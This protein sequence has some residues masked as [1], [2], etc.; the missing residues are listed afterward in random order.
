MKGQLAYRCE[1]GFSKWRCMVYAGVQP[2]RSNPGQGA[3]S[4]GF[5]AAR[6][7]I[8]REGPEG[9]ILKGDI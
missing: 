8:A 3:C 6:L 5:A 4:R 9:D 7:S 2:K 1:H